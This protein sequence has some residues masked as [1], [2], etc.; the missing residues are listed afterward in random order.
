MKHFKRENR[1]HIKELFSVKTGVAL[2]SPR[3]RIKVA[4]VLAAAIACFCLLAGFSGDL[5][6]GLSGDELGFSA[7]YLGQGIVEIR[8]ENHSGKNITFQPK[9]KLMYWESSEEVP[10]S[11]PVAFTGRKIPAGSAGTMTLDLN[12]AYDIAQLEKPL[13]GDHYYFILTN[14]E[15]LFGQDWMC[16]VSF[17]ENTPEPPEP[18][19]PLPAAQADPAL[20]EAVFPELAPFFQEATTDLT[21]MRG[22]QEDYF[23]ACGEILASFGGQVVPSACPAL[24]IDGME[25]E[26]LFDNAVPADRQHWLTS[27]HW[28]SVD[29][30]GIPVG[31]SASER[32]LVVYALVPARAGDYDGGAG[33]PVA[34]YMAYEAARIG[35]KE[36]CAFIHGQLVP[37]AQLEQQVIY[38]DDSY[39]CF[40]VTDYF[41]TDLQAHTDSILKGQPHH[42]DQGIRQRIE[43]I[44]AFYRTRSSIE[45]RFYYNIPSTP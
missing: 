36:D 6:S 12:G 28:E 17:G 25:P 1:N 11:G 19:E 2:P 18:V 34:Y 23:A 45:N 14:N 39:I 4:L 8:V 38:Q 7:A 9:V 33:V 29:R 43:N 22:R 37:F 20:A 32:A 41:Y 30:Y 44:A 26:P 27:L 3:P 21:K 15:F 10:A 24:S 42:M 40:D 13:I 16:S 35:S 31:T 5:A